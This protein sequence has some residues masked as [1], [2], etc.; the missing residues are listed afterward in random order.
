MKKTKN[1][2]VALT[3][4]VQEQVCVVIA[5]VIIGAIENYQVACFH[6]MLKERTIDPSSISS[7][8]GVKR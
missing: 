4:V 7:R 6:L 5:F 1:A 8:F 2:V 3:Q